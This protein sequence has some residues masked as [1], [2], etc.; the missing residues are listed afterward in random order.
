[1]FPP[2]L[3]I[4]FQG[5][6]LIDLPLRANSH[7]PTHWHAETCHE[8]R[9]GPSDF[10]HFGLGGA[11]RLSFT[12]RIFPI[13]YFSQGWLGRSSIARVERAHSYRARSASRRTT[14]LPIPSFGGRALREHRRS[15][16]SIPASAPGAQDQRGCPSNPFYRGRSASNKDGL[17]TPFLSFR[18]REIS[19][20][21]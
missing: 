3:F 11:A 16:G 19:I 15:S 6:G 14:R 10:P 13:P 12:A 5:W 17:A 7:P 20:Q 18:V 4:V 1:M 9:R 8:P 2:S 21:S